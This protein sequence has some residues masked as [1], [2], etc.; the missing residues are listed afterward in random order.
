[1]SSRTFD[2]ETLLDLI[3]NAIPLGMLAFMTGLFVLYNPFGTDLTNQAIQLSLVI[4]PFG[5][6]LVLTYFSARAVAKAENKMEES[7]EKSDAMTSD[8]PPE[9]AAAIGADEL[10]DE[11][12]TDDE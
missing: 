1:M 12:S 2:R 6:L 7:S 9:D 4:I 10:V 11:A 8:E 3:V 5:A